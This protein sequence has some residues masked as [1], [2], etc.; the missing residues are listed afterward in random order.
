VIRNVD[1]H[2]F[3]GMLYWC[4]DEWCR[5]ES[6]LGAYWLVLV[7]CA[8]LSSIWRQTVV[9]FDCSKPPEDVDSR[10]VELLAQRV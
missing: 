7:I 8:M 10:V 2:W 1:H 5:I 3:C 9:G 4:A 6:G